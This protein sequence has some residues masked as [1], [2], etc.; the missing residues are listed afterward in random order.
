MQA[1]VAGSVDLAGR[2]PEHDLLTQQQDW[3]RSVGHILRS[4]D[5]VPLVLE[6]RIE[7]EGLAEREARRV[8][9]SFEDVDHQADARTSVWAG[10]RS[11][12]DCSSRGRSAR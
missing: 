4:A 2:P 12:V 10:A 5:D 11:G 1:Q 9:G 7:A 8:D 3:D 6:D